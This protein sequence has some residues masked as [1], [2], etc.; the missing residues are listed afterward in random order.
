MSLI[1]IG[2]ILVA[3]LNF[4]MAILILLRNPRNKINIYFFLVVLFLGF[5]S[6]GEGIFRESTTASAALFWA[7]FENL[8]G[9]LVAVFFVFF[10]IHYP[11][12]SF[13]LKSSHLWLMF[14]GALSVF[15]VASQPMYIYEAILQPHNN[16][17][18]SHALGRYYFSIFF[19]AYTVAGFYFLIKKYFESRG[20]I[21]R[22]LFF[23]LLATGIM[24]FFG[25]FLGI[26]V[27]AVTAKDNVWFTPYFSIPMVVVLVWFIFKKD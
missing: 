26:I 18:I 19:V 21:R 11:Y 12:E 6:L 25:T 1:N 4:G 5:W 15:A 20:S 8:S 24:G 7:R 22:N 16:D 2:L 17:F 9:F 23:I 10:A 3:G 27:T 14:L 13:K